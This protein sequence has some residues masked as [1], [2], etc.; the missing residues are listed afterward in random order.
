MLNDLNLVFLF[1]DGSCKLP[2]FQTQASL[3]SYGMQV[4]ILF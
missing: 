3:K 2:C 1:V 4:I